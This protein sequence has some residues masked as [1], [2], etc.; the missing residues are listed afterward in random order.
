MNYWYIQHP[1]P[2]CW[3]K[4]VW[5]KWVQDVLISS[6]KRFCSKQNLPM[7]GINQPQHL[8]K[9]KASFRKFMCLKFL[10]LVPA[11]VLPHWVSW[12]H[13]ILSCKYILT[14]DGQSGYMTLSLPLPTF[15][16]SD[17]LVR[18]YRLEKSSVPAGEWLQVSKAGWECPRE[19][20]NTATGSCGGGRGPHPSQALDS[21]FVPVSGSL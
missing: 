13:Y 19:P 3:E 17:S 6:N 20:W 15:Q 8:V 16:D 12:A 4:E 11:Q 10:V 21:P 14:E 7:V 9:D 2:L 1:K 18:H 5:P